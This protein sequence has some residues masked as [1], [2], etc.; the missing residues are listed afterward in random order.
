MSWQAESLKQKA[1][2]DQGY[3]PIT[4][5]MITDVALTT[6]LVLISQLF[7]IFH[8][9]ILRSSVHWSDTDLYVT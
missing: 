7:L 8:L 1:E 5:K 3:F 9:S 2:W 6:A 4:V